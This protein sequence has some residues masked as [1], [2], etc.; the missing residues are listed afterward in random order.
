MAKYAFYKLPK[1]KQNKLKMALQLFWVSLVPQL[2]LQLPAVEIA[3]GKGLLVNLWNFFLCKSYMA[4]SI[5]SINILNA[6]LFVSC[7]SGRTWFLR[8]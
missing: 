8:I 6:T 1:W 5:S 3:G 2:F 4:S 7:C